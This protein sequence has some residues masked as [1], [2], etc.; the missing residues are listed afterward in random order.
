MRRWFLYTFAARFRSFPRCK[1]PNQ[2]NRSVPKDADR[3]GAKVERRKGSKRC[4]CH[5]GPRKWANES[6]YHVTRHNSLAPNYTHNNSVR[7]KFRFG[8]RRETLHH[9]VTNPPTNAVKMKFLKV[10]RV[11]IITRGRYAGKKVRR[12]RS[13]HRFH[14]AC[15]E[16]ALRRPEEEKK[17][18]L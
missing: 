15:S 16:R 12:P 3:S 8:S 2:S 1:E 14:T 6:A 7:P 17:N 11:A 9:P 18:T 13:S 10:G 5:I 4:T